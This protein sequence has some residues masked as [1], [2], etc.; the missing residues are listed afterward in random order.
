MLVTV[1]NWFS[2]NLMSTHQQFLCLCK[3]HGIIKC[4]SA[5]VHGNRG[6][7]HCTRQEYH[8]VL[9]LLQAETGGR[10]GKNSAAQLL[11]CHM[12]I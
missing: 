10:G 11:V 2:T 3:H 4:A 1:S 12:P 8:W 7:M 5:D 9:W 6:G